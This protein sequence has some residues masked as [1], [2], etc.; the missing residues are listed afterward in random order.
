MSIDAAPDIAAQVAAQA[1]AI[2]QPAPES[3]PAGPAAAA[4][5]SKDLP[6]PL[7]GKSDFASGAGRAAHIRNHGMARPDGRPGAG[8]DTSRV[9]GGSGGGSAKRS[10]PTMDEV[11]QFI[12]EKI[13]PQFL[14]AAHMFVGL[15]KEALAT[16]LTDAQT[17]TVEWPSHLVTPLG[18]MVQLDSTAVWVYSAA[19]VHGQDTWLAEK[20]EVWGRKAL[21]VALV[22]GVAWVTMQHLA[23]LAQLK[24]MMEQ[25][26][27]AGA[28]AA[29]RAQAQAQ[30]SG[31]YEGVA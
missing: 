21:P 12:D 7:C 28:E 17:G 15:P 26:A 18:Q 14:V 9:G 8:V 2:G 4:G 10:K 31:D 23:K 19:Y 30:A 27:K 3:S 11:R 13:Q 29:A 22:A 24:A 20:L 1:A 16:P 25:A 6:C 5:P